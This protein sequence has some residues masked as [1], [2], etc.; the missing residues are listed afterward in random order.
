MAKTKTHKQKNPGDV[1]PSGIA[2]LHCKSVLFYLSSVKRHL[3]YAHK[4][5][6]IT[7][8]AHIDK[9]RLE[10][11]KDQAKEVEGNRVCPI[12]A[13]PAEFT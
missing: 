6:A 1:I 2:C 3:E 12:D 11:Y 4:Y 8:K 9:L 7:A 13:C 10:I 5:D